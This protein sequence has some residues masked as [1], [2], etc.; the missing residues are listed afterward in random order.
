M[1]IFANVL[2]ADTWEKKNKST[3]GFTN[4]TGSLHKILIWKVGTTIIKSIIPTY[5]YLPRGSIDFTF[6]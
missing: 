2:H 6:L 4:W 1:P 5:M 3:L